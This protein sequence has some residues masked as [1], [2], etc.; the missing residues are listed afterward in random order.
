MRAEAY[1]EMAALE[2]RH[3]WF[4]GRRA[5]IAALLARAGVRPP[6]TMLD[7]GCGTGGNLLAFGGLGPAEGIDDA[8]EA[9]AVCHQRGLSRV[10]QGTLDALPYDDEAFRLILATDVL[11]HLDDDIGALRE[12]RRVAAPGAVL[13]VTVPAH[14]WLWSA[15]DEA[16]HHRRR[17]RR[18]ELLDRARGAGW[19]PEV[20]TGFN[21]LLLGPIAVARVARRAGDGTDHDATPPALDRVLVQPMR[22]EGKLVARG[23]DLP[24]GVSLGLALRAA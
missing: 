5:V 13:I 10:V 19:A 17:Y 6:V 8:P 24:T 3:W 16:V 9:V 18:R 2:E 1:A 23:V 11:E 21:T 20:V 22:L 14:P 12:L 7:A 15:H 4:R